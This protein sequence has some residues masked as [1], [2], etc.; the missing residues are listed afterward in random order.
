LRLARNLF[1]VYDI[2]FQSKCSRVAREFTT[3][4]SV[5]HLFLGRELDVL[6]FGMWG[7][8]SDDWTVEDCSFHS[9][10]HHGVREQSSDAVVA[11]G[12]IGVAEVFLEGLPVHA[13]VSFEEAEVGEQPVR[14]LSAI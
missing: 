5:D 4:D 10:S 2:L 11:I 3:Y 12:G 14:A 13:V 8:E 1:S 9:A 7:R 6:D